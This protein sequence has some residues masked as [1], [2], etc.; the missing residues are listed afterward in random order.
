MGKDLLYNLRLKDLIGMR[1][2]LGTVANDA[3]DAEQWAIEFSGKL[4]CPSYIAHF[5]YCTH[6]SA[7]EL[8]GDH[9]S[10]SPRKG[11]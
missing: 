5:T 1:D 9:R 6:S 11:P 3:T 8:A 4:V 10:G 7:E 2:T